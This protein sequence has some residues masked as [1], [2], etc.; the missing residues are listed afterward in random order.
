[1]AL[2]EGTS[3][4][5]GTSEAVILLRVEDVSMDTSLMKALALYPVTVVTILAFPILG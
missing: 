3:H 2:E 4:P 5:Q 1:V